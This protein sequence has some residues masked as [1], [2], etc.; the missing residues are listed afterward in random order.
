MNPHMRKENNRDYKI[1]SLPI[2]SIKYIYKGKVRFVTQTIHIQLKL[3]FNIIFS[4]EI[5]RI[6]ALL[7]S[8][9]NK[10]ILMQY[11]IF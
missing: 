7:S 9:V 8:G 11:A 2:K 10:K 4:K 3:S 6:K 1:I 5:F